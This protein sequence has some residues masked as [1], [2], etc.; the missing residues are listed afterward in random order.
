LAVRESRNQSEK[1]ASA[2]AKMP[3]D[4]VSL[5]VNPKAAALSR[6]EPNLAIQESDIDRTAMGELI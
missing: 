4:G 2:K 6:L 1:E 3:V 5:S